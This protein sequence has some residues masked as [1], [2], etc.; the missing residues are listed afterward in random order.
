MSSFWQWFIAIGTVSFIVWCVWL[1]W[2]SGKQGPSDTADS[3]LVGH[4]WDGDLEE[5]NNPAPKWW[6]YLYMI[7]IAFTVAYLA[8]YPG[9]GVYDGFLGWSQEGQYEEEVARAEER[10][11]PIYERF[12]AMSFSELVVNDDANALGSSLYA[13]YCS[14][15]HGSDARGAPGYPNLTDDAWLYGKSEDA[16]VRT[17]TYGRNAIMPALGA[18]LGGDEGIDN[19]VTY[20]QSL[21][22]P[23][24]DGPSSSQAMFGALC[25]ACHGMDGKGNQMLG[26]PNLTDDAWLY[27]G[28]RDAIR[29]SIVNGRNGMMPAHGEFL[30]ENRVRILAAYV[31][32]LS[33]S[34]QGME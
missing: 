33:D 9:L 18:A 6:L 16:I 10:Y 5:W 19:M 11:A 30:G 28:S 24:I 13:S 21:S 14:T 29:Y 34:D 20:V 25:S 7:T 3:E 15:C 2:W 26:G 31:A 1:V 4:K 8:A 27:G 12:A 32:S 22:D 17:I 23:S